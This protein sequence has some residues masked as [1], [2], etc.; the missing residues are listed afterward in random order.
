MNT[1]RRMKQF[2]TCSFKSIFLIFLLI[3]SYTKAYSQEKEEN[4]GAEEVVEVNAVVEEK[5]PLRD[6]VR[7]AYSKDPF[8]I[9]IGIDLLKLGS[10]A[11]DFETKY[12]GQIGLSYRN[13][14]LIAEAGYGYYASELAYKNSDDYEVEGNYYRIG[15]DY[16]FTLGVKS[17]LLLGLRYGQ[18]SFQDKGTFE[19][20]SE[21]WNNYTYSVERTD[22]EANWGE[23]ILGTQTQIMKNVYFGWYF[24]FRKILDRT[25]YEPIDIYNIPGYGKSIDNSIPA[26]NL[27]L[28]YKFSF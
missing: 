19:I 14:T 10:F 21:L 9:Q 23:F 18:S 17:H 7:L 5:N 11:L 26:L 6:S 24:R 25:T 8:G 4:T 1:N 27:F 3:A 22:A 2:F 28:K 12:E 16:A 20:E 15:I 13:I